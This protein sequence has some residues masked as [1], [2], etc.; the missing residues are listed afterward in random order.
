M[1]LIEVSTPAHR[2]AF[3]RLPVRLYKND[4]K[5]IRP[6]DQDIEAVFDPAKNKF[7]A[8][9]ECTRWIIQNG[10]GETVGRVAAFIN[11]N[12]AFTYDQPT[13][14]MGFF[15]CINHRETAFQLFDACKE[16]LQTRG[17]EAMDGPINFGDRNKWWGLLVEGFTAPNYGMFY[18]HPYYR[19]LFEAYGFEDYYRQYTYF[20][21]V[22]EPLH[23]IV[24]KKAERIF[25]NPD[26]AFRHIEKDKL[27]KY[28][29]DFRTIYNKA[30][31][32]RGDVPEM[33]PDQLKAVMKEF[34]PILDED[35]VWFAY[36]KQEPVGFFV[37]LP[38]MNQIFRH[39]NGKLDL[40]G[41]L[42]FLWHRRR[43]TCTKM[44]GLVFGFIPEFQ[45]KGLESA[46]V[47]AAGKH[48]QVPGQHYQDFEMN[49]IGDFHPTMMKMVEIMGGKACKTHITYRKL[50]DES[51]PFRRAP[52]VS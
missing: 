34:K 37:M 3:L 16:W 23:P 35:I 28:G 50:F 39:V 46:I 33:T 48:V 45:G 40:P 14:G 19:D 11:R 1:H 10:N 15:E 2:T 24:V 13:G 49:W 6:L 4:P 8:H 31:A 18:H 41:I 17:M 52:V 43:R 38:E 30:W 12:S 22:K 36:Y 5:W 9:G 25:A 42:K 51:K 44:F 21:K 32:D 29:E 47:A 7:F 27:G 26:Y 20:R